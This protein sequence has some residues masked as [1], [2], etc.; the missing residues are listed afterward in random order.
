M[1]KRLARC[2]AVAE[3]VLGEMIGSLRPPGRAV[4]VCWNVGNAA[5]DGIRDKES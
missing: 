2:D 1:S 3:S 4:L 5:S